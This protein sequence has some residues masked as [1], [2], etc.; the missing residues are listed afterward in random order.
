MSGWKYHVGEGVFEIEIKN[1]EFKDILRL[2]KIRGRSRINAVFNKEVDMIEECED[3]RI[4]RV[5]NDKIHRGGV[6]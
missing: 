2:D 6:L 5:Q 1:V 3:K 4:K